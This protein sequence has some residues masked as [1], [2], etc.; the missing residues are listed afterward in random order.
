MPV[1]RAKKNSERTAGDTLVASSQEEKK[2]GTGPGHYLSVTRPAG[3]LRSLITLIGYGVLF[4]AMVVA[5]LMVDGPPHLPEHSWS[6]QEILNKLNGPASG[7]P[8][9][10]AR[11]LAATT[12]WLI[13]GYLLLTVLTQ[14]LVTAIFALSVRI[15][16]GNPGKVAAALLKKTRRFTLPPLRRALDGLLLSTLLFSIATSAASASGYS[17]NGKASAATL[18]LDPPGHDTFDSVPRPGP[19]VIAQPP[20]FRIKGATGAYS[21]IPASSHALEENSL[22]VALAQTVASPAQDCAA[23]RQSPAESGSAFST[24]QYTVQPGDSLWK[25]AEEYYGRGQDYIKIYR[26]NL[27]KAVGGGQHF[28]SAGVIKPGW[29]LTIPDARITTATTNGSNSLPVQEFYTVRPGDSLRAIAQK[30]LGNEMRWPE[31]WQLN[32]GHKMTDGRTAADPDLIYPGWQLRLP[33]N[34][35]AATTPTGL[36]EASTA[37]SSL[38]QPGPAQ[39]SPAPASANTGGTANGAVTPIPAGNQAGNTG[40]GPVMP[41]APAPPTVTPLPAPQELPQPGP[42]AGVQNP[43]TAHLL[44]PAPTATLTP[45]PTPATSS[46]PQ[47]QNIE[48]SGSNQAAN[49]PA[50]T[51]RPGSASSQ[52][53]S[54]KPSSSSHQPD[55]LNLPWQ[56]IVAGIT[57]ALSLGFGLKLIARA[58]RQRWNGGQAVERQYEPESG[59]FQKEAPVLRAVP[60]V[61]I[62]EKNRESGYATTERPLELIRYRKI[63]N[64]NADKAN[65]VLVELQKLF[66]EAGLPLLTPVSCTEGRESL[67]YT[68]T[69]APTGI[70]VYLDLSPVTLQPVFFPDY[71]SGYYYDDEEAI[72]TEE[73]E[74]NS[75]GGLF[76]HSLRGALNNDEVS[77]EELSVPELIESHFG[78]SATVERAGDAIAVTLEELQ[79]GWLFASLNKGSSGEKGVDNTVS[80][81]SEEEKEAAENIESGRVSLRPDSYNRHARAL[82]ELY[83][84]EEGQADLKEAPQTD[85]IPAIETDGEEDREEKSFAL[86]TLGATLPESEPST[87]LDE[88][89]HFHLSLESGH[90]LL[91]AGQEDEA[92]RTVLYNSLFQAMC[93]A[94]PQSLEVD[95]V[96]L[97]V[98]MTAEAARSQLEEAETAGD[99]EAKERLQEAWENVQLWQELARFPEAA[100]V[101]RGDEEGE[102]RW[103]IELLAWLEELETEIN[104]RSVEQAKFLEGEAPAYHPVARIAGISDLA[105]V[106]AVCGQRLIAVFESG[107]DYGVY[108]AAAVSYEALSGAVRL[109]R[110]LAVAVQSGAGEGQNLVFQPGQMPLLLKNFNN[111]ALFATEDEKLSKLV[112]GSTA[113]LNLEGEGDMLL[114]LAGSQSN[115]L[116]GFKLTG[117]VRESCLKLIGEPEQEDT[118]NEAEKKPV[119]E[120]EAPTAGEPATGIEPQ[121]NPAPAQPVPCQEEKT[122]EPK[123]EASESVVTRPEVRPEGSLLETE[124]KSGDTESSSENV[125]QPEHRA[126][127]NP[128]VA[129]LF[130]LRQDLIR[131][132]LITPVLD[133]HIIHGLDL[134]FSLLP[135]RHNSY[136]LSTGSFFSPEEVTGVYRLLRRNNLTL[137]EL[138]EEFLLE[139]ALPGNSL[140]CRQLDREMERLTGLALSGEKPATAAISPEDAEICNTVS[141]LLWNTCYGLESDNLTPHFARNELELIAYLSLEPKGQSREHIYGELFDEG[142]KVAPR[143]AFDTRLSRTRS[144][145]TRLLSLYLQLTFDTNFGLAQP[146]LGGYKESSPKD[147]LLT[148]GEKNEKGKASAPFEINKYDFFKDDYYGK[149][150][151]NPALVRVDDW[152]MLHLLTLAGYEKS[153]NPRL[154]FEKIEQVHNWIAATVQT[155]G[156]RA[157]EN[158]M[159]TSIVNPLGSFGDRCQWETLEHKRTAILEL[160]YNTNLYLGNYH[161]AKNPG[162]AYYHYAQAHAVFPTFDDPVFG[163]MQISHIEG[164]IQAVRRVFNNY[165]KHCRKDDLPVSDIVV[166]CYRGYT[167][168][169]I[170]CSEG[171]RKTRSTGSKSA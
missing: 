24:I 129:K 66:G 112:C 114:K 104:R 128:V 9:D 45:S 124:N 161:K 74:E 96:D 68:F 27:G 21:F 78:C 73:E 26:A 32:R 100:E 41:V 140:S 39:P 153:R 65:L 117:T 22:F 79:P 167:G 105:A 61:S 118:L 170:T 98:A 92:A 54:P 83:Q 164:D 138:E 121:E 165:V 88:R 89:R 2:A 36:E 19:G 4:A 157:G 147:Y 25:L 145:L 139:N 71:E 69:G 169:K 37:P 49:N 58:L 150:R 50:L 48:T 34:V 159:L 137:A 44:A 72:E 30:L 97:P 77:D 63:E 123:T 160:W 52:E 13:V 127:S 108:F 5:L 158:L 101:I 162:K 16:G 156:E 149:F 10:F 11:Y 7:L 42:T 131:E 15:H 95:L 70:P 111:V 43:Q 53:A 154:Y 1:I 85:N 155:H 94:T 60:E 6:W 166:G 90:L 142:K 130:G 107:I 133:I 110:Q 86:L 35:M 141:R 56:F 28:S 18:D 144:S 115:R 40:Q 47:A 116:K 122:E 33:P 81:N 146:K 106:A 23:A 14:V 103:H 31:I 168:E 143:H 59:L 126:P 134:R 93:A 17:E 163:L 84:E 120:P 102:E 12:G 20:A 148:V 151:L 8:L 3:R 46:T 99:S 51:P 91:V 38:P 171:R 82:A 136:S 64:I 109:P 152:E 80:H 87:S 119:E 76:R 67:S 132:R 125:G 113:A 75:G 29:I 57:G 55:A 135:A 62:D